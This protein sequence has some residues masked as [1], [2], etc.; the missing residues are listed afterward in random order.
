[1][2]STAA[3]LKEVQDTQFKL[4]IMSLL[5]AA[6]I[7]RKLVDSKRWTYS[8]KKELLVQVETIQWAITELTNN[9]SNGEQSK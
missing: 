9:Q 5:G 2:N 1:M 8:Q 4:K 3:L 7:I 6:A